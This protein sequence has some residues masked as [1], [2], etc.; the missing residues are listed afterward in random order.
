MI[1]EINTE[2]RPW[3]WLLELGFLGLVIAEIE[4]DCH[5]TWQ[6]ELGFLRLV[7]A[8]IEM[9]WHGIWQLEF[10]LPGW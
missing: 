2:R 9:D 8:E 6:L 10:G 4:T 5:G 1:A 3:T 7:I